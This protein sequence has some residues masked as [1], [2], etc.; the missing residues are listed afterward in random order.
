MEKISLRFKIKN[1][2]LVNMLNLFKFNIFE[3]LFYL[4]NKFEVS[5][6]ENIDL[7]NQ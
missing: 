6:S 5:L 7:W 3:T 4:I 1:G 2:L